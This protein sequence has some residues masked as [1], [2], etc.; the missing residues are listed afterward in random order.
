[1]TDHASP[2]PPILLNGLGRD[3]TKTPS[4][5]LGDLMQLQKQQQIAIDKGSTDGSV[6]YVE[7]LPVHD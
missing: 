1:M 6:D 4:G 2:V 5:L 3:N 7:S